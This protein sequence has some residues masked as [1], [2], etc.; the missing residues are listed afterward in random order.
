MQ[1]NPNEVMRRGIISNIFNQEEQVQ[2]NGIDLT[3]GESVTV[4]SKGYVNI[5]VREKF[6]MQDC[7]GIIVIRSSL[8]RKGIFCSSGVFD[9]GFSGVGGLSLYNLSDQPISLTPGS[10]IAQ[11]IIFQ[12]DA[13][14]QYDGFYNHN[15]TIQSKM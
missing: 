2:Q 15:K 6:D 4:P 12:G 13:A 8:S 7:F 5:A 1:V 11:M 3:I 14:K 10:R 9:S